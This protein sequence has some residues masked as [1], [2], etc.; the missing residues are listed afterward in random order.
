MNLFCVLYGT[1]VL[2]RGWQRMFGLTESLPISYQKEKQKNCYQPSTDRLNTRTPLHFACSTGLADVVKLLADKEADLSKAD[3][4][5]RGCIQLAANAQGE[6]S[7][8]ANWLRDNFPDL[9]ETYGVGRAPG[10]KTRGSVAASFRRTTGPKQRPH[11]AVS[12]KGETGKGGGCEPKGGTIPKGG[13]QSSGRKGGSSSSAGQKGDRMEQ[14]N[15]LYSDHIQQMQQLQWH[16]QQQQ[17]H[18]QQ[19]WYQQQQQ[20]WSG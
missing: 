16:Q 2:H 1:V 7:T 12:H 5:G 9:P 15:Q 6:K 3:G 17:W 13:R 20:W 14:W 8:L 10:E 18:Q 19:Q 4:K 11:A